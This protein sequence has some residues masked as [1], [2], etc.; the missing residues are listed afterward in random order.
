MRRACRLLIV[1]MVVGVLQWCPTPA[2]AGQ[3]P[4]GAAW[5]LAPCV[6]PS[7]TRT[8]VVALWTSTAATTFTTVIEGE[9]D[10]VVQVGAGRVKLL[11]YQILASDP[12][13]TIGVAVGDA[14][15]EV[16]RFAVAGCA[17]TAQSGTPGPVTADFAAAC[18][19]AGRLTVGVTVT[20]TST[21]SVR[22]LVGHPTAAEPGGVLDAVVAP[23][24]GSSEI[25]RSNS[26]GTYVAVYGDRLLDAPFQLPFAMCDASVG[27][28][29]TGLEQGPS[30]AADQSEHSSPSAAGVPGLPTPGVSDVPSAAAT[31]DAPASLAAPE[32]TRDPVSG[33]PEP[34]ATGDLMV[35]AGGRTED[36]T[37]PSDS[38]GR[39]WLVWLLPVLV[40]LVAV[41]RTTAGRRR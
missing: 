37:I 12:A 40:C 4:A 22:M 35:S 20:N 14:S 32:A 26:P 16:N 23:P 18:D 41:A 38:G 3:L 19:A 30:G 25:W 21:A 33:V 29:S 7:T 13:M 15:R 1:A 34:G 9:T 39:S 27:S 24:G 6:D 17:S 2:W 36:D 31:V 5:Y 8:A 10:A 28:A 11:S